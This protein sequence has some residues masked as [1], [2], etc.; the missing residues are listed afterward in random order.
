MAQPI[1]NLALGSKI[2]FGRYGVNGTAPS[3]IKWIVVDKDRAVNGYPG[4]SV[5]V[6]SEYLVDILPMGLESQPGNEYWFDNCKMGT[7][8]SDETNGFMKDF[9]NDEKAAMPTMKWR[10]Y[11][12][13]I[14]RE[15]V[16][17][18]SLP[19]LRELNYGSS[20]YDTNN[21]AYIAS[22]ISVI[23]NGYLS[24]QAYENYAST[25]EA[26][27]GTT[28][29]TKYWTRDCYPS[30]SRVTMYAPTVYYYAGSPYTYN[31]YRTYPYSIR[32]ITNILDATLV[33]DTVDAD[34]YYIVLPSNTL[35]TIN[36]VETAELATLF[37]C[38][39]DFTKEAT[40]TIVIMACNNAYDD[41]PAWED[42][43]TNVLNQTTYNFINTTKTA[44]KA[45][46]SVKVTITKAG[47]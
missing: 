35:E 30:S 34:G 41:T 20:A 18:V 6:L 42:V 28:T 23:N 11:N 3:I 39:I 13:D 15:H 24:L 45:G 36:T 4:N 43:T 25:Q 5:T 40:D 26:V 32:P 31:Y 19:S 14:Y 7:W 33:S 44:D 10:S 37:L 12:Y 2:K 46:V 22:N 9:T 29:R 38:K 21:M 27:S 16:S 1:S 17:K 8:L 47:A